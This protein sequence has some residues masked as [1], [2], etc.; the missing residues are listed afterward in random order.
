MHVISF[1]CLKVCGCKYFLCKFNF[2]VIGESDGWIKFKMSKMTQNGNIF[3]YHFHFLYFNLNTH[4]QR[5]I[6]TYA[7]TPN[8]C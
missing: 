4:A 5:Y 8:K 7:Y 2:L 3:A 6:H 1:D